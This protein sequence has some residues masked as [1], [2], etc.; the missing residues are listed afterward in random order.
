M[1]MILSQQNRHPRD[2]RIVFHEDTHTYEVDGSSAGIISVTTFIHH[3]FPTFNADAVLKKMK[4]K[5]EKYPG[6]SDAEIKK[7]WNENGKKASGQGTGMHRSIELY[8]N[9]VGVDGDG[10]NKESKENKEF[11]YF[12]QFH[13][14][15]IV[16]RGLSPYRTEWS[17]F[18]GDIDLAGQLDMLYKKPDGTYGL[19]DWKRVK[20]IKKNN[21]YREYG[22]GV[23]RDV[24]HCNYNHYSL[25]LNIYKKIL[26]TRYDLRISEMCLVILHPEN[27]NYIMIPVGEE[28]M[29]YVDLL[30]DER[31]HE[32]RKG[33]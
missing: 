23:L 7:A 15:V 27:D 20:D 2:E 32:I 31:Y 24:E 28:M 19:Y 33:E 13:N 29:R 18:D 1:N 26:E 9:G 6:M 12:L 25:Q 10:E 21:P 14:E 30:F 3:N 22:M 4:N 8:Y 11:S 5:K 16:P 17:I